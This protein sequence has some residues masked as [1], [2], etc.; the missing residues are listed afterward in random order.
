[1]QKN[2]ANITPLMLACK[3]GSRNTDAINLLLDARVNPHIR[4]ADGNTSLHYSI[5]GGCSKW[6]LG[7]L[8][9]HGVDVNA[10]NK[11]NVTVLMLACK[12]RDTDAINLLLDLRADP[13]IADADGDTSLHHSIE[14]GCYKETLQAIIDHGADVNKTNKN[15]ATALMLACKKGNIDA[16]NAFLNLRP[17]LFNLRAN[18]NIADAEGST[19]L[20]HAIEGCCNKETLQ[21]I[22]KHGAK[23]NARCKNDVTPLMLACK[24]GNTE[25]VNVFLKLGADPKI[26]DANGN[27]SLHHAVEGGCCKETLQAIIDHG[28][29]VNE[30]NKNNVTALMLVSTKGNTDAI[31]VLLDS[32]ADS[33][34]PVAEGNT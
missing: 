18:P 3:K 7:K 2:N 10:K 22:I 27:T 1:M 8:I 31:N 5:E 13:R 15:N 16:I 20:H 12:K 34:F 9:D 28:G 14:G 33:S 4:D 26:K 30:T 6:T 32:R 25:A 11:N 21:L 29:D 17:V 23:V 19:S 24:K